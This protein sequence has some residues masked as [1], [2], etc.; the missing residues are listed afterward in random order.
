MSTDANH[1]MRVVTSDA[2]TGELI[3]ER[4]I[5]DTYCLVTNGRC[6]VDGVTNY[7]NGTIQIILKTRKE[8]D[9]ES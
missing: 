8:E 4:T 2:K 3:G 9:G 7:G 6:Y 1:G 5:R